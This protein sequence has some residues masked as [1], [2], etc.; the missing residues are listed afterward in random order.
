MD[1]KI[2]YASQIPLSAQF[3][4]SE[5]NTQVAIGKIA[6]AVFGTSTIVDGL[7]CSGMTPASL[8]IQIGPGHIFELENV[9]GNAFGS[10]LADVSHSIIKMG[11]NLDVTEFTLTPP[12]TAGQAVDFLVQAQLYEYDGDPLVLPYVNSANPSVP[13]TGPSNSGISQ[14]T[15]R[16]CAVFLSIKS[17]VAATSGTQVTPSPD[18]GYVGLYSVTVP[19]GATTLDGSN[20][21][22]LDTAPFIFKKLPDLPRWVQSGEYHWGDDTGS[23]NA[24]IAKLSPV[25]FQYKKGMNIFIKKMASANTG[26]MT[27]NLVGPDG[28]MLGAVSLLDATGA[29]IA[30]GN[31]PGSFVLHAVY[32]GT[33][34]RW[35]NGSISNVSISSITATSGEGVTVGGAAPYPVSLNFPG[36]SADT[37]TGLDLFAFYDHEGA[38][39]K[40]IDYATLA[41]MISSSFAGL[42]GMQ[43]WNSAGS[44]TYTKTAGAK[45]ILAFVTGGGGGGGARSGGPIASGGGGGGGTIFAMINVTAVSTVALTVGAGGTSGNNSVGGNGGNSTFALNSMVGKGGTGGRVPNSLNSNPGTYGQG[46]PGGGTDGT[47][48]S[49]GGGAGTVGAYVDAGTGGNSFWGGGGRGGDDINFGGAGAMGIAPGAGGG[50]GD[51]SAPGGAGA[52]GM[53]L[54]LEFA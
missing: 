33:S 42:V 21:S 30:A 36:L 38:H 28:T 7:H 39:H 31:M 25:P 35:I 48:I 54:I 46:G 8:T 29:Q 20:I 41:A 1:R 45:R 26:N 3:L 37:P 40:V 44:Y 27:V 53:V 32:D 5:R 17:G 14:P 6:E 18:P 15:T 43:Y 13:F 47:G 50:G 51:G 12:E 23:A 34:F 4:Q 52:A 22:E 49:L 24:I 11:V 16:K 10:L 19:Y 9:D 2:F